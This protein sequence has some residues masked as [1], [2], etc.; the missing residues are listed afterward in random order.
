M[1]PQGN[2]HGKGGG[3]EEDKR[4]PPPYVWVGAGKPLANWLTVPTD[5]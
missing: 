4:H 2:Q 1:V 3:G 5:M